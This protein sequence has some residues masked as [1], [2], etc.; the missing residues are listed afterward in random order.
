MELAASDATL[1][2]LPTTLYN[3]GVLVVSQLHVLCPFTLGASVFPSTTLRYGGRYYRYDPRLLL[4]DNQ[5]HSPMSLRSA[6]VEGTIRSCPN[7]DKSNVGT[8]APKTSLNEDSCV[9]TYG[10]APDDFSNATFELSEANIRHFFIS[11]NSFVYAIDNLPMASSVDPC[12][13][14]VRRWKR[15][16]SSCTDV[17]ASAR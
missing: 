9:V 5:A 4:L 7:T 11:G 12:S 1:A 15:L 13:T 8:Y 6:T 16:N 14:S 2:T 3:T 17:G 10:C